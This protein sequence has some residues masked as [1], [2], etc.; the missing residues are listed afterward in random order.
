MIQYKAVVLAAGEG[1]RMKSK[2]PKVL[3]EI[4]GRPMLAWVLEALEEVNVDKS[5]VVCGR[6]MAEV[7]A[8]FSNRAT[9]VE[10]AE[11]KGSG[12]AVMCAAE[13]LGDFDGYTLIVAG[14]MPLLRGETIYRMTEMVEM[15]DYECVL[16]TAEVDDPFGYGRIVRD[17]NGDVLKIVEEKDADAEQRAIREI[18]A[19]C[20]CVKNDLLL[21]CLPEF[22]PQNAQGEYYLTDLVEIL[23]GKGH[24][25]GAY[26]AR[27]Y[28]ECMGVNDRAQL[29]QATA[30][31]QRRINT[32]HMQNGVT[33]MD[34]EHIYIDPE[35]RIGMDSVIYPGVTL[36]RGCVI[37]EDVTLY[38][39]SRLEHSSVGEGTV[40]QN[41]VLIDA[42]VGSN[43]KVGPYAYLRPDSV[44]GDHCRVGDFVEIKNSTIGN[45]TKVSHLTYV[46]DADLG[47]NINIGC[48]VVF[49]NYDG[50]RKY[51]TKIEDDVFIGCNTNLIS[52]VMVEKGAYIAAGTTV[53]ED[54]PESSFTIG[55]VRQ[56]VK[57]DWKDKRK[58]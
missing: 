11:R 55:R 32:H 46:G 17:G 10:Q 8:R 36:E 24:R 50:K 28:T 56:T 37:G 53:T 18:N 29:A 19:S 7:K 6:G 47:R 49:V 21:E 30:E 5:I 9:Y 54:L 40:V 45:G 38:P 16:L 12:H 44:V 35:T 27:D 4:L 3:H 57:S 22:K 26:K 58:D 23:H 31:W 39:G 51:R 2:R 52:P 15:D 43:C 42:Q 34:P 33:L 13:A 14:D 48:G 1:T 41:S 25:I 20:Y